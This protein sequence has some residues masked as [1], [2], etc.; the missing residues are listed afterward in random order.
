MNR[1]GWPL[2][3][4][5]LLTAAPAGAQ[6]APIT[7]ARVAPASVVTVPFALPPS[8][9]QVVRANEH[10]DYEIRVNEGFRLLGQSAGRLRLEPDELAILPITFSV[11]TDVTAGEHLALEARFHSSYGTDLASVLVT[12]EERAGLRISLSTDKAEARVG[13]DLVVGYELVNVGNAP[14]SVRLRIDSDL[15]EIVDAPETILI[16]PFETARGT[17]SVR[18]ERRTL[19]GT[20]GGILVTAEGRST[21]AHHRV[22]VPVA[23]SEAWMDRWARIPTSVF[24]GTSLLPG[25]DARAASPAYG[26]ESFGM[27]RPGVLLSVRA[28]SAPRD[29]SAFAFRGYQMGPRLL[30]EVGTANFSAAVGQLYSGTSPL[31]GYA[32]QGA[33]GRVSFGRGNFA[34][35]AHV[36]TP[37]DASGNAVGGMQYAGGVEERTR[38]GSFGLEAVSEDRGASPQISAR[39]LRSALL[40]YRSPGPS[41]HTLRL[42]AGWM[43]LVYPDLAEAADGPALSGRY[44]YSKG[45]S[46]LDLSAR[47]RPTTAADAGLPPN[48]LRMSGTTSLNPSNGLLAE[49]FVVDRPRMAGPSADRIRGLTWGAYLLDGPDRYEIRFH[50]KSTEGVEPYA[51]RTVE[52]VV[53]SRLGPGF[54][55]AR[56]EVGEAAS[57][58]DRGLLVRLNAGINF[59]SSRG[60]G[61]AGIV[62]YQ[63]P[64]TTGDLSFQVSGSYRVAPPLEVFGSL[65]TSL[66]DFDPLRRTIAEVGTQVDITP[67]LAVLA[68]FERAEGAYASASSRYSIGIRKGLPLPLPVRQQRSVQG[69]VFDDSN[70]N[71][72]Y[73]VGE[74]LLDGIRLEMGSFLSST[75]DGRFEFPADAPLGPLTVDPASLGSSYLPPSILAADGS[76]LLQVPVHSPVSLRVRLFLDANANGIQEPLEMPVIEGTVNIRATSGETWS[77]PVGADGSVSL[78]AMRPGTFTISVDPE[79]LP[80]RALA[81]EPLKINAS[82]GSKLDLK[83]PIGQ[84]AIRFEKAE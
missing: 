76:E 28:H 14:D 26:I 42:D 33:G 9:V 80:A 23:R 61:R 39:S 82:G 75:R 29:V 59:R 63:S 66:S 69:V 32:L 40:T 49:A 51:S 21:G 70:G 31:S 10:L 54:L 50:M 58:A 62:Y 17:F 1:S 8:V 20:V 72:R 71:G 37:L 43:Q 57:A 46:L 45:R 52:G 7:R 38:V 56:L 25:P 81:P 5:A 12:V 55:D 36:A 11:G 27:I 74:S 24:V 2:V 48:E 64:L 4:A 44:T 79:S 6:E 73:D 30:A 84:R 47:T 65:S 16:E 15:G 19:A 3:V 13:E 18:P 83:L 77:V 22:E 41:A 34:A 68:A 35:R 60:W 53:S 78:S 67:T